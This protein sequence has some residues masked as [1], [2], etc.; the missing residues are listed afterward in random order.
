LEDV[1]S[2][3]IAALAKLEHLEEFL[4]H[5]N[6]VDRYG[7]SSN[8]FHLCLKLMADLRVSGLRVKIDLKTDRLLTGFASSAFERLMRKPLPTN[9]LAL[10][11]LVLKRASEMPVG[12]V[13]PDLKTLYLI[14]PGRHFSLLGL[15]SLTELGLEEVKQ[16]QFEQILTSIGHQLLSLAVHVKDT[17]YVDAVFRMCPELQKLYITDRPRN[18]IGL[19][20]PMEDHKCLVEFGFAKKHFKSQL[21]SFEPKHLLQILKAMP[22]LS[23]WRIRN[24]F[25]SMPECKLISEA[26]EKNEILRNLELFN[27]VN[28]VVGDDENSDDDDSVATSLKADNKVLR[29]LIDHCPKL[30]T[31]E[32]KMSYIY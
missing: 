25:F 24:Y 20:E 16:Q 12:V 3:G 1:S 7:E 6:E 8:A 22:N 23:V 19:N 2:K 11:E 32:L 10:R 15:L 21:S 14:S 13:L 27:M 28:K 17:L 26:L 31:V 18:F 5:H 9:Q 4:Y 30:S 29:S